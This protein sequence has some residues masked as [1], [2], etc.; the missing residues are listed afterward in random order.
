MAAAEQAATMASLQI[1]QG[2]VKD[3]LVLCP[4]SQHMILLNVHLM[5]CMQR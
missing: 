3:I 1:L 4:F 2:E 5:L